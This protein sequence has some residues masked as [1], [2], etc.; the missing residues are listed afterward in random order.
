MGL[1]SNPQDYSQGM[2]SSWSLNGTGVPFV[3]GAFTW[4]MV[5]MVTGRRVALAPSYLAG[6]K[7]KQAQTAAIEVEKIQGPILLISGGDDQ[8]WPS[9]DMGRAIM[10]RLKANGHTFNDQHLEYPEAGHSIFL[11]ALPGGTSEGSMVFGGTREANA[12]ASNDSWEK[13]L[14]F[15]EQWGMGS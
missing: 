8:M 9:S 12:Q 10:D 3:T 11:P 15:L 4:D 5:G 14:L 1:Y 13:V 6:L 2:K 7:S